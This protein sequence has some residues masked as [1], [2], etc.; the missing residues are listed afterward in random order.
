MKEKSEV[1]YIF[2][3]FNSMIQTQFQTKV[4]VFRTNNTKDYFNYL[5]CEY[6]MD[7]GIV[8]QSSCV[9]TPQQNGVVERKNRHLLEMA[10][11]IM[12]TTN[13]PKYFWGKA[14]LTATYLI[15]RMPSRVLK[16]QT[17]CQAILHSY[18]DT[19]IISSLPLKVFG[20]TT[21]VHIHQ[22]HSSKLDPKAIKC[23]FLGY[24]PT[25]K[26]YNVTR[27]SLGNSML[28]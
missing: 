18:P 10:R 17:P 19:Q 28:L 22:H 8:H 2:K 12:F 27:L 11:S 5:L 21:F 15:N 4:K 26:G 9:Y 20:C 7:Q 14:V 23:L 25:K 6:L 24:S 13:V 3:I 1:G 16:F